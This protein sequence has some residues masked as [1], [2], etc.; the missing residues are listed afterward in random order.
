MVNLSTT[1]TYLYLFDLIKRAGNA[2]S[3]SSRPNSLKYH[4]KDKPYKV[5]ALK[6][7]TAQ[8]WDLLLFMW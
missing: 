3:Y 8:T 4:R 7:Q 5:R 2:F 6:F 1:K